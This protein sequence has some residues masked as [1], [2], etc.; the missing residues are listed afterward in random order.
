MN[1]ASIRK[2]LVITHFLYVFYLALVRTKFCLKSIDVF[3]A[4]HTKIL[5]ILSY[6]SV[7][8]GFLGM[9]FISFDIVKGLYNILFASAA[10]TVGV[11]LPF[12][13]KGAF[14]V[15]FAY[16]LISIILVMIV[17]EFSHGIFARLY[18]VRIK[19]TGLAF[20]GA[21][22]PIIPGAFVDIDEKQLNKKSVFQQLSVF[23]AG[24]FANF[25]FAALFFVILISLIPLV[26]VFY[27]P[28]GVKITEIVK[29]SPA[30][31]TGLAVGSVITNID[32]KTIKTSDDFSAAFDGKIRGNKISINSMDIILSDK[33]NKP[34]LGVLV[35]QDYYLTKDSLFAPVVRW[36]KELVFW[37][38][39]L[40]LGV[41]AFNL[42]P[43]GPLDG[44]RMAHALL[45]SFLPNKHAHRV[46]VT[47]NTFLFAVLGTTI[48][49]SFM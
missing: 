47:V 31:I 1:L 49:Y 23:S 24:P 5:S 15:P 22:V 26:D 27:Q 21:I 45:C 16:W 3:A 11:V 39:A 34:F 12:E 30:E 43:L 33:N 20:A 2:S 36:L 18:S 28:N 32:G 19:S 48:V 7:F 9:A 29:N 4:K 44:G 10:P 38:F 41:G 37:L 6:F 8:L 25:V 42:L 40:N 14:Y 35:E 13:V 17:H 46:M